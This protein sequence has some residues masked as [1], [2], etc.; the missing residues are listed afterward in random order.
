MIQYSDVLQS[1]TF[2]DGLFCPVLSCRILLQ[3]QI[4]LCFTIGS[5]SESY[6]FVS[7]SF[8]SYDILPYHVILCFLISYFV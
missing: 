1:A 7:Y 6:D 5:H 8:I 2:Y 4:K 3:K